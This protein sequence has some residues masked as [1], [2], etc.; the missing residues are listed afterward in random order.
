MITLANPCLWAAAEEPLEEEEEDGGRPRRAWKLG[1]SEVVVG[2]NGPPA[3][4]SAR[5]LCP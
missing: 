4:D 3:R 1:A 5:P 2:Q